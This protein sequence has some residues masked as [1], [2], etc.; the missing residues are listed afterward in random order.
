[1]SVV[2]KGEAY[3]DLLPMARDLMAR[4]DHFRENAPEENKV[5]YAPPQVLY[6]DKN[7]CDNDVGTPVSKL[8]ESYN[9]DGAVVDGWCTDDPNSM[10]VSISF[11]L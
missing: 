5:H 2:T 6:V 4:F 8:F 9:E 1:M 3:E 11:N 10:V 7:C